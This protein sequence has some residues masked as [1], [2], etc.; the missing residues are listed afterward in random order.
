MYRNSNF[1]PFLV[2]NIGGFDRMNDVVT[3]SLYL[4]KIII[5]KP[6]S[7]IRIDWFYL[8]WLKSTYVRLIVIE[9]VLLAL[10]E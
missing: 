4:A 10:A 3:L 9:R 7:L 6:K 5:S 1:A 8:R 2:I